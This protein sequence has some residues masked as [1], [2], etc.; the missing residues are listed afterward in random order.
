MKKILMLAFLSVSLCLFS[1]TT[2]RKELYKG[3]YGCG[4][5][6]KVKDGD[7]SVY[8]HY[9]FQNAKYQHI[10]DIGG[11]VLMEKDELLLL[12]DNLIKLTEI[13][14][15]VSVDEKTKYYTLSRYDFSLEIYLIDKEGKY[16]IFTK[17]QAK[18]FANDIKSNMIKFFE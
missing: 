17:Q 8:F 11:I 15:G 16:T 2:Q 12:A 18:K 13:E 3:L 1:Q 4:V 5:T 10:S 9:T 7:T 6:E 14:K